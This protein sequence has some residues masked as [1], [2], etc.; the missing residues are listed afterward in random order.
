[1]NHQEKT[2][3]DN[4]EQNPLQSEEVTEHTELINVETEQEAENHNQ[5]EEID[6]LNHQIELL[7]DKL[8]R[9]AAEAENLRKRYEKLIDK[10]KDYAIMNFAKDLIN[11]ID[12]LGRALEYKNQEDVPV[13]SLISGIEMTKDELDSVF[14]KHGLQSIEPTPGEKFDYN[15]HHAISQIVTDEYNQDSIVNTMQPGYKIKERLL[16]PA[17]VTVAKKAE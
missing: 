15:F 16:R 14:K 6:N 9:N 5:T 4:A 17:I 3:E 11:V 12:N 2:K 10:A 7:Q 13:S 1:M 8:L